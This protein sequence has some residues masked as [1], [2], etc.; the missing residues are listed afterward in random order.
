MTEQ[1]QR[2]IHDPTG[3]SLSEDEQF[4]SASWIY[5]LL[6]AGM[7][8]GYKVGAKTF[9]HRESI[10]ALRKNHAIFKPRGPLAKNAAA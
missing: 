1:S 9:I 5:E 8:T 4:G 2:P 3:R 10:E 6:G 7:L